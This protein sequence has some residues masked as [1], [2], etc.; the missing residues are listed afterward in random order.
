M[1]SKRGKERDAFCFN[2]HYL[3]LEINGDHLL[4]TDRQRHILN[5]IL[6]YHMNVMKLIIV[7]LG[8]NDHGYNKFTPIANKICLII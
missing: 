4:L 6:R 5:L 1:I 7:K 2:F 8:Y 3:L